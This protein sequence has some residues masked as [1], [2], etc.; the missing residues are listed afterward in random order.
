MPH[1]AA[2]WLPLAILLLGLGLWNWR[3]QTVPNMILYP[4]MVYFTGV[5]M[6][7]TETLFWA[8]AAAMVV[9]FY[10]YVGGEGLTRLVGG[11]GIIKLIIMVTLATSLVVGVSTF[12]VTV[13]FAAA[14]R[15]V[16]YRSDRIYSVWRNGLAAV[17]VVVLALAVALVTEH[18]LATWLLAA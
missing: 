2:I 16:A 6:F 5:S 8:Q 9:F 17:P 10:Y 1:L 12:I 11:G 18:V 15:F 14:L 13:A 7:L 3:E 4:A